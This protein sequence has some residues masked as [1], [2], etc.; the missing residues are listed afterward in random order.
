[1][2]I[3]IEAKTVTPWHIAASCTFVGGA[4]ALVSWYQPWF[5]M[6]FSTPNT[7]PFIESPYAVVQDPSGYAAWLVLGV[8][9]AV[10][11]SGLS[12]FAWHKPQ[13][14]AVQTALIAGLGIAIFAVL[15]DM[16]VPR[17]FTNEHAPGVSLLPEWGVYLMLLSFVLC[18]AASI[19]LWRHMRSMRA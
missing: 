14:I 12:L 6:H 15:G 9:L 7:Q 13:L 5:T 3:A 1:M 16:G 17:F 11:L 10:A 19:M 8:S 2:K 4:L 18:L